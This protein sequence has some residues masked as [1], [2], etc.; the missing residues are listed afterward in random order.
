MQL[1]RFLNYWCTLRLG[2][3]IQ[4]RNTA[5]AFRDHVEKTKERNEAIEVTAADVRK[6]GVV[7]KN[8]EENRQPGIEAALQRI[9]AL[10]VGV[11]M[12]PLLW[13]YTED[14]SEESRQSAVG[15]LESFLVRRVLCSLGTM[16]LN[17]LFIELVDHLSK[18]A[19][20]PADQVVIDYLSKQKR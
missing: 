15:A 8:I 18:R 1:D 9:K 19:D 20:E 6:V 17:Y 7:Y 16:G 4:I 3:Y 12:P 13:L 11:I 2:K 10:E 5:A 14:V